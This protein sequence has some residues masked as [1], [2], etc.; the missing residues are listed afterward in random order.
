MIFD[1]LAMVVNEFCC[2]KTRVNLYKIPFNINYFTIVINFPE[3][4]LRKSGRLFASLQA[5]LNA[6]RSGIQ[7][8]WEK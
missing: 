1:N 5:S 4:I 2:K 6:A 3:I 8:F 7:G